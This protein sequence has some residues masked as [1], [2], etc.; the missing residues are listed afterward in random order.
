[1]KVAF[2]Y[3][4]EPAAETS[5]PQ[6][7]TAYP[8]VLDLDGT[9]LRTDL[10]LEAILQY[11]KREPL[12]VFLL[13]MWALRGV[14]HL[15]RQVAARTELA[16]D[17]LPINEP[18][19]AYAREAAE[20]GRP[21]IA[22]TAANRHLAERVCARFGFISEV[23]ASCDRVNLKGARKARALRAK[24][25][26]G[27]AY[28]GDAAAD[29]PVWREAAFGIFAGKDRRL[30]DRLTDL[31]TLE[32]DF[33]RTPPTARDW[34]RAL[35][36]HQWAKNALIFVPLMLAGHLRE[37]SAW[38][39]CTCAFAAMCLAASATYLVN[40]LFDLDAD[41]QHWNKR[42]RPFASGTIGIPAGVA[43]AISLLG[44]ALALAWLGG[45]LP[46]LGAITLY[47]GL[48]LAYSL[49]L[50]RVPV[51]DV[52]LLAA[53]FTMRL[54]AGAIAAQ[55]HLS[56][57]LA[58]FSMFLFLS[59]ALAKRSTEIGRKSASDSGFSHGR[60]YVAADA[61]LVAALGVS[62]AAAAV[63]LLVLY[64]IHEAFGAPIYGSPQLLWASPVFLGLW[65]GRVWLLCGR[66]LLHDDP[67]AFAVTDRASLWLGFGMLASFSSAALIA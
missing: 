33:S 9:L 23:L 12:G 19:A 41:R 29:L 5:V 48:T 60:G 26:G 3:E 51:L 30:L 59:L 36:V 67:V 2:A 22:A 32:A 34:F 50:K 4:F 13:F 10:L 24:F 65:L 11:L 28:A 40:D 15:K 18:L 57:W 16:V 38:A 17:L 61:P 63:L 43:A 39:A 44:A 7:N 47:C 37:L 55:V 58:V 49:H 66:G 8:L 56:S 6:L 31:T 25:P 27:Y 54:G 64:L 52:M 62:S 1:M 53:L 46:V 20:T 14:A 35:R 42:S 45:G 21:V